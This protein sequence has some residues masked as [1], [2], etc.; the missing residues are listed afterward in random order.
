MTALLDEIRAHRLPDPSLARA[1]RRAARVSQARLA[2]ELGVSRVTV[3]R[4]EAGTRRPTGAIAR[5]YAVLLTQMQ[6]ETI[7]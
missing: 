6:E 1:V 4:W 5:A 3:A 2:Q 7:R